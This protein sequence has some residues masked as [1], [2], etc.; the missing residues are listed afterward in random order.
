MGPPLA[1][2]VVAAAPDEAPFVVMSFEC[3]FSKISS[4][5]S[6]FYEFKRLMSAAFGA[7]SPALGTSTVR[8]RSRCIPW[9]PW[10][11][12][13]GQMIFIVR[14]ANFAILFRFLARAR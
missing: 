3:D 14:M 4:S 11:A 12:R 1:A 9:L 10:L 13:I 6:A 7:R 5:T 8:R 2:A